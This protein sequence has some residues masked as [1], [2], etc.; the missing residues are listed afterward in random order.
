MATDFRIWTAIFGN[1]PTWIRARPGKEEGC[2]IAR[3]FVSPGGTRRAM[4]FNLLGMLDLIFAVALGIMTNRGPAQVLYTRPTAELLT[5]FPLALV[6][7]FP[8]STRVSAAGGL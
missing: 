1:S 7:N 3:S 8:G 6:P 5:Y 4:I 2:W